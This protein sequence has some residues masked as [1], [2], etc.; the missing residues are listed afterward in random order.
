[1]AHFSR[2]ISFILFLLPFAICTDIKFLFGPSLSS[3][4][5]IFLPSDADYTVNVTQRWDRFS[6]PGYVGAI[7]PASEQ[8]IQNIVRRHPY[9][10]SKACAQGPYTKVRSE[11]PQRTK[12]HSSSPE[13]V[14]E[15]RQ[16]SVVFMTGLMSILATSIQYISMPRRTV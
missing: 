6:E 14:M 5:Q 16:L 2:T 10:Y 15:R 7:K 9:H 13:V 12:F 4:A 3:S 11:L 8:D 1:M